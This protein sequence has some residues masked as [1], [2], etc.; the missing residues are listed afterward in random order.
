MDIAHAGEIALLCEGVLRARG[1]APGHNGRYYYPVEHNQFMAGAR[2]TAIADRETGKVYTVLHGRPMGGVAR[3][4]EVTP[5]EVCVET[6]HY[7]EVPYITSNI[8]DYMNPP[9]ARHI[10]LT[11]GLDL[12]TPCLP[13]HP[14]SLRVQFQEAILPEEGAKII[15][16][17]SKTY[18]GAGYVPYIA[19]YPLG[20]RNLQPLQLAGPKG[21]YA[22]SEGWRML[23]PTGRKI[24]VPDV[25]S[26]KMIPVHLG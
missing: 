8:A 25:Y 6:R 16:L 24:M 14:P 22:P 20:A 12:C 7:T 3:V 17:P 4:G 10:R 15:H 9:Y 18:P 21:R 2:A 23:A 5:E 19:C 11:N 1:D 26:H 13:L